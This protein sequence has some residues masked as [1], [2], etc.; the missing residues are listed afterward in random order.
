MVSALLVTKSLASFSPPHRHFQ[1]PLYFK[2]T[3]TYFTS[4]FILF[5]FMC[6]RCS[7]F[8]FISI[9]FSAQLLL[10]LTTYH[11]RL[12]MNCCV[13]QQRIFKS[14]ILSYVFLN[15]DFIYD[16]LLA[17][18]STSLFFARSMWLS[19]LHFF[20]FT[21]LYFASACWF[22]SM[23]RFVF[24]ISAITEQ[25]QTDQGFILIM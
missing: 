19:A 10:L 3:D 2:S 23:L 8:H 11:I 15:T 12:H 24:K 6:V 9:H 16:A 5:Y 1:P 7:S 17:V 4:A 25:K 22:G 20:H 18:G 21:P 14:F 13:I